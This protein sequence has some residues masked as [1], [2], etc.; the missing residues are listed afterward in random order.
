MAIIMRSSGQ[1]RDQGDNRKQIYTWVGCG[2]VMVLTLVSV[3]PNMGS[4]DKPDYSKF[5]SQRMQ[6]LASLP[7]GTDAEADNFLRNNP[8]Y[9]NVS[10]ADL[11]GSLFSSEDKAERQAKDE[12]EGVPPP[13]DPEYREIARQREKAEEDAYIRQ[14]R[15]ERRKRESEAFDQRRERVTQKERERAKKISKKKNVTQAPVRKQNEKTQ[16]ANLS[17]RSG[18]FS[19]G[20]GSTGV[21]GSIWRY[22]GNNTKTGQT[23]S[24]PANHNLTA[25]DVAF[26]KGRSADLYR[27][28]VESK[29]GENAQ[30]AEGA[31]TGAM[32]AFQDGVTP[33]GLE[34]DEQ[35]L[36]L[37]EVPEGVDASLQDELERSIGDEVNKQESNKKSS[38]TANGKNC[39]I[40][41]SNCMN[42]CTGEFVT[43]CY[44]T[45][46]WTNLGNT[47]VQSFFNC[48]TSGCWTNW[49]SGHD[50]LVINNAD[51]S[52]TVL[53][54]DRSQHKYI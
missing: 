23:G 19:S 39:T 13:P 10:N 9:A 32:D 49:T 43:A 4:E 26:A 25:Q 27:A 15:I 51:G 21:T 42:T 12:T 52:Q 48:V 2:L 50:P 40:N 37:D 33:E 53:Q 54:W 30:S 7:F 38:D 28:G 1:K 6:D 17:S 46:F 20:G 14:S 8:E 29:K 3:I 35:E 31:A 34:N 22:E 36:G 45:N 41:E 44:W 18:G 11:L 24:M 5:S 47:A 16:Q